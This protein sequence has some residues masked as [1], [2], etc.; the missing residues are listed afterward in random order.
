MTT[1]PA[2]AD[3]IPLETRTSNDTT[4]NLPAAPELV[5]KAG[6]SQAGYWRD[7][8]HYRELF[9]FLAWRD[10][11]VRYKQTV[12]GVSWAL[13][14]PLMTTLVFTFIFGKVAQ[15]PSHSAPYPVLVLAA[16][17]PWQLFASSLTGAGDSL[18]SN[19][20]LISKIYFPRMIIPLAAVVVALVN[21]L[22]ALVL[23][24][25][26]MLFYQVLPTW[27][28]VGLIPF[29]I[30]AM[31]AAA[32]AGLITSAMTVRYRDLRFIVPFVVQIGFFISPVGYAVSV[33]PEKYQ[34]LYWMNPLVGV[35]EGFR[36]SI[37]GGKIPI[38]WAGFSVSIL[39]I[40]GLFALG[41]TLFRAVERSAADY[42]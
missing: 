7:L 25:A 16:M 2:V 19:A 15:L 13:L 20:G 26:M 22:I 14:Q 31:A 40:A 37:L 1:R 32:G 36:W 42:I 38:H 17:L 5:I 9:F 23:L 29:T 27:R 28:L 41:T 12:A 8:W 33:V 3:T 35:I 11:L 21:F 24:A 30:L 39:L 18:L 4:K 34:W 10:I 6:A